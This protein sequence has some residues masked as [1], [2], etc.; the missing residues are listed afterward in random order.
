MFDWFK[1]LFK[2]RIEI[3]EID[4]PGVEGDFHLGGFFVQAVPRVGE[5]VIIENWYDGEVI[6]VEHQYAQ[7]GEV[8]E[9]L[10]YVQKGR[11]R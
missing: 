8:R 6:A 9:V 4:N 2:T 5:R 10:V 11:E 7:G 1:N 3:I